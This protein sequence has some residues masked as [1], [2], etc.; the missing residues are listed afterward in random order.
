MDRNECGKQTTHF[1]HE[2]SFS[3]LMCDAHLN[4]EMRF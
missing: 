4:G 2:I 3:D 1:A